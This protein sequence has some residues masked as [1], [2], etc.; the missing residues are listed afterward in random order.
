M[1]NFN[2]PLGHLPVGVF[3][4]PHT[5]TN[6]TVQTALEITAGT[7]EFVGATGTGTLAFT[8]DT[9]EP[10]GLLDAHIVLNLILP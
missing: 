3:D 9:F 7:G 1:Q 8:Y 5:D 4:F 10:H 6:N 2:S